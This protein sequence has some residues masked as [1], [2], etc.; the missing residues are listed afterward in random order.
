M[1]ANLPAI[2]QI[3]LQTGSLLRYKTIYNYPILLVV[4]NLLFTAQSVYRVPNDVQAIQLEIME[5]GPVQANVRV[6][7]DF[8]SY[9]SGNS[10]PIFIVGNI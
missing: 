7:E 5:N 4:Y 8:L 6:Y 3:E 1:P 2:I 9:K 10:T